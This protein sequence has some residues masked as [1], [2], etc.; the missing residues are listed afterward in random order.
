MTSF[1]VNQTDADSNK[2]IKKNNFTHQSLT[3]LNFGYSSETTDMISPEYLNTFSLPLMADNITLLPL[4]S[5][6]Q[7]AG[8]S[9]HH[10]N[11]LD[12]TDFFGFE[13]TFVNQI[14]RDWIQSK[15]T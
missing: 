1:V 11:K 6:N 10:L 3:L 5:H 13:F 12:Q 8:S 7:D 15:H 4:S 9:S 14:Q 2:E